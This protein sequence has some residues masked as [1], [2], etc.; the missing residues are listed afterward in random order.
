M[1]SV[2]AFYA[3][4]KSID[5][6]VN[7]TVGRALDLFDIDLGLV[8]RWNGREDAPLARNEG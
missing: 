6:I 4:P 1:P 3:R 8:K 5:D 7:H 2:P